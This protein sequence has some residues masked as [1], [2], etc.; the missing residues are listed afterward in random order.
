MFGPGSWMLLPCSLRLCCQRR[1]AA[2]RPSMMASDEPVVEVPSAALLSPDSLFTFGC[3]QRCERIEM[4]RAC[5]AIVAGYS[6]WSLRFTFI[7]S[8]MS[9][10]AGAGIHVCTNDAR[11]R[12]GR[13]SSS[14]SSESSWYAASSDMPWSGMW[15]LGTGSVMY[16]P[17]CANV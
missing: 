1:L 4:H 14:S 3:F 17:A 15:Y 10:C 5:T 13:P 9:R 8:D 6:S 11:F 16:R 12:F 7:V 2:S